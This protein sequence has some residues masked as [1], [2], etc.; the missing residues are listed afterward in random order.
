MA[1]QL[2]LTQELVHPDSEV[3]SSLHGENHIDPQNLRYF[4][5][6]VY[7]EMIRQDKFVEY[8]CLRD[9]KL[10]EETKLPRIIQALRSLIPLLWLIVIVVVIIPLIGQ[11][12]IAKAFQTPDSVSS[13][14]TTTLV[15][16]AGTYASTNEPQKINW[17]RVDYEIKLS[18]KK[19]HKV[20]ED[21]AEKELEIW[22]ESLVE[23]VDNNFLNWY[24]G[25]FNQKQLEYQSLFAGLSG[26]VN[27]WLNPDSPTA[28]EKIAESVTI[29][30]QTE[31]AKRVIVPTISQ[32]RLESITDR[33]AKVYMNELNT[34]IS[35]IPTQLKIPKGDWNRYLE[36]TSINFADVEGKMLNLP[37]KELVTGGAYVAIKPII[38]PLVPKVGSA[39]VAK[40]AGKAG[41]KLAAKTGKVLAGQIGG[42]MLDCT[43][44]VGILIWDI[45][46]TNHTA[47]IEKPILRQN[48][49]EY[50]DVV[51]DSIL[52]NPE[53]GIM[54]IIDQI[55]QSILDSIQLARRVS[56]NHFN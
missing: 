46:E 8:L 34:N 56:Y 21:Y 9:I 12:V 4:L 16:T 36:D 38:L 10:K 42:T 43:V 30:F 23:R 37:L 52:T 35:Q 40:L 2:D 55:D 24:F 19:A 29:S 54:G 3:Q 39:V 25:Y 17:D 26:G 51:K 33:T 15:Q 50:L 32:L 18:M 31:F 11:I 22:K 49:V 41:A 45:W 1:Q 47:N 48:L 20:A 53:H 5:G 13:E 44:G 14:S 6:K 7:L 28:E 27:H